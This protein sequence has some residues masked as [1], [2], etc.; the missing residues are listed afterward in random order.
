MGFSAGPSGKDLY[1]WKVKFFG[2]TLDSE[3]GQDL[4]NHYQ[5]HPPPQHKIAALI[6][7]KKAEEE[8]RE[9][10]EKGEEYKAPEP[11]IHQSEI[12]LEM[13]FMS[14]YPKSAPLFRVISPVLQLS[15]SVFPTEMET[16]SSSNNSNNKLQLSPSLHPDSKNAKKKLLSVSRHLES[17]ED[18]WNPNEPLSS[19]LMKIRSKL[20][21]T[22]RVDLTADV[23]IFLCLAVVTKLLTNLI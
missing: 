7:A 18:G 19:A 11:V 2:F 14:D 5:I 15:E 3:L 22:A 9:K 4:A 20:M 10:K 1:H 8:K 13:K 12:C 16:D 17:H 6:A 21:C 23:R